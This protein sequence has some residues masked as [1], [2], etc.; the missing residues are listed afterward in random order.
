MGTDIS[1]YAEVRRNGHWELAEP[2]E[3]NGLWSEGFDEEGP[4][5]MPRALSTTRNYALFAILANVA[6]PMRALTPFDYI[7]EPRG[8]P[9]D[10]SEHLLDW[11]TVW[12][13]KVFS[14]SWLLLNELLAF[15]WHGKQIVRRG[16]VDP[17]VAHLFPPGRRGFPLAEWPKS[18]PITMANQGRGDEV[19]WIENYAEAVGPE[20]MIESMNQLNQY[21]QPQDVRV[22]FWFDN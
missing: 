1:I 17:A 7:C 6:N 5:L 3:K 14:E 2:L 10:M 15:D 8:V 16:K 21:G 22:V 11:Y 12:K 20:F 4:A 19:N 13:G 9:R 18:L